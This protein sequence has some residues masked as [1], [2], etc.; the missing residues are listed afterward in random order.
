VLGKI[1]DG[2]IFV[3]ASGQSNIE[4]AQHAKA[5]LENVHAKILGVV[6]TKIDKKSSGAYYYRYYNY[7]KYYYDN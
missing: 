2:V 1:A 6:L 3:I 4:M 5:A 7:D